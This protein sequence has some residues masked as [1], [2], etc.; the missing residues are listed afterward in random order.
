MN[1]NTSE[2]HPR[3][4]LIIFLIIM[5]CDTTTYTFPP[6]P[7]HRLRWLLKIMHR[8][9][10][11]TSELHEAMWYVRI[12]IFVFLPPFFFFNFTRIY[13]KPPQE[14]LMERSAFSW[15]AAFFHA[16]CNW[17]LLGMQWFPRVHGLVKQPFHSQLLQYNRFF[18]QFPPCLPC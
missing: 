11:G 12:G 1:Q 10:Q 15:V 16:A 4:L 5:H 8:D 3:I 9:C 7:L 17:Q 13:L 6:S 14:V 2:L 18:S